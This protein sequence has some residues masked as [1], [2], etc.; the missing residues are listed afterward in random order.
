M[1]ADFP[2]PWKVV[3]A[4]GEFRVQDAP[5]KGAEHLI[6]AANGALG[7]LP[8]GL[9]P[10]ASVKPKSEPGSLFAEYRRDHRHFPRIAMR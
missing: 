9:L 2:A 7:M 8:L 4:T 6:V 10:T 1:T 3:E 5:W